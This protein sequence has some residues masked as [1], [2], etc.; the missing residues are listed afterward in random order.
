M[1]LSLCESPDV[2]KVMKIVNFIIKIIRIIVPIILIIAASTTMAHAVSDGDIGKVSKKVIIQFISA[3]LVFM[4]PY[5]VHLI[6][7]LVYGEDIYKECI[8]EITNDTIINAYVKNMEKLVKR[9]EKTLE[10]VDYNN[11]MGYIINLPENRRNSYYKRLEEVKKKIDKKREEELAKRPKPSTTMTGTIVGEKPDYTYTFEGDGNGY[12]ELN[13]QG[14]TYLVVKSYL[15]D[16]A[17]FLRRARVYQA[18]DPL[19]SDMCM[20][21]ADTHAWGL[22]TNNRT[23]TAENGAH[24]TGGGH[25]AKFIDSDWN[26][27][28]NILYNELLNGRPLVIQVNGRKDGTSRHFVTAVGFKKTVTEGDDLQQTDLLIIDSWDALIKRMDTPG[29]RFFTTGEA[30]GKTYKGYYIFYI[31]PESRKYGK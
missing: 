14:Q 24:Y 12:V 31:R 10:M 20:G 9:A 6:S 21:F 23:Y 30:C 13:Y 28:Q 3:I 11:A 17:N 22:Y 2:L 15:Q 1:I 7:N 27:I 26:K 5:F 25:Y 8:R 4:I 18:S 19:Y 29:A 16:Y